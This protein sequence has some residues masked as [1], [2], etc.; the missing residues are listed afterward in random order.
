MYCTLRYRAG[1][2]FVL[3]KREN[4]KR[5]SPVKKYFK[6]S[7]SVLILGFTGKPQTSLIKDANVFF[8]FFLLVFLFVCVGGEGLSHILYVCSLALF[9][10]L[11]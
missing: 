9:F 11:R 2:I 5:F 1:K 8:C 4:G 3:R 7:R 10:S 6:K